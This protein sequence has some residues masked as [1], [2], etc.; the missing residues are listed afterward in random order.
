[1][2]LGQYKTTASI[3][4]YWPTY[5]LTYEDVDEMLDLGQAEPARIAAWRNVANWG[6]TPGQ[7]ISIQ[8]PEAMIKD[9]EITI[10][11]LE[12]SQARQ[13]VAEMMILAG[14]VAGQYGQAHNIALPLGGQPQ[15]RPRR[16]SCYS[17]RQDPSELCEASLYDQ[18]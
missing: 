3:P 15:A 9:D 5:R 2:K 12:D 16:K 6:G 7:A 13:L 8:L 11:V 14:E 18:E 1:M 10:E 4:V 17:Y